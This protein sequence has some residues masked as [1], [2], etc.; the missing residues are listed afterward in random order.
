MLNTTVLTIVHRHAQQY[1]YRVHSRTHAE[2][3]HQVCIGQ[4][5]LSFSSTSLSQES[6][7]PAIMRS[8]E[9]ERVLV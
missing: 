5:F 4:L 3:A 6:I 8:R 9:T 1:L 2:P 7:A